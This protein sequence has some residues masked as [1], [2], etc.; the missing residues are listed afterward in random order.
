MHE[1]DGFNFDLQSLTE[2][3]SDEYVHSFQPTQPS[4][5][6]DSP[7]TCVESCCEFHCVLSNGE[8]AD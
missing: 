1:S 7:K 3:R 5:L 2:P 8:D 6:S 4:R